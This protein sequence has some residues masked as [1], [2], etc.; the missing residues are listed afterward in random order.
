[1]QKHAVIVNDDESCL[2]LYDEFVH[3]WWWAL[4]DELVQIKIHVLK[5]K[6]EY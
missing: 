6:V 5:H 4:S 1:M 3:S 2:Y